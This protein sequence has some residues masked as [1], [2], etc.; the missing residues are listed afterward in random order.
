MSKKL[1][2][3]LDFMIIVVM[4]ISACANPMPT[5]TQTYTPL[6]T[7]VPT[8]TQTSTPLP[9][10]APTV[11]LTP[12]RPGIPAPIVPDV[13][14]KITVDNVSKLA[15]LTS[16]GEG[17][18]LN[19]QLSPDKKWIVFGTANGV[20]VLDANTLKKALFLPT[21]IKPYGI[22]FIDGGNKLTARDCFQGYVWAFPEGEEIS[23]LQ[24]KWVDHPYWWGCTSFPDSK[25]EYAFGYVKLPPSE[26]MVGLYRLS[27]GDVQ[28]TLNYKIKDFIRSTEEKLI[29][30]NAEKNLIAIIDAEENLVIIQYQ[31]GKILKEIP[32]NGIKELFFSPDG[33]TLIG[34]FDNQIKFWS[35]DDFQLI[36]T[37]TAYGLQSFKFSPDNSI[38]AIFT[39]DKTIRLLRVSDRKLIDATTGI[40]LAFTSDSQGVIVDK[41]KGSVGYYNINPDRSKV[42]LANSFQGKGA[43]NFYG[44]YN[45]FALAG[46]SDDRTTLLIL[47]NVDST[48]W[49][50]KEIVIY[51]LLTGSLLQKYSLFPEFRAAIVTDVAW[52][53]SLET[54][55]VLIEDVG[56]TTSF[57]VLDLKSGSF[58]KISDSDFVLKALNFSSKSDLVVSLRGNEVYSWD[59]K[60]NSYWQLSGYQN[61]LPDWPVMPKISFSP[62]DKMILVSDVFNVTHFY[63]P[64]DYSTFQA[65]KEGKFLYLKNGYY[66]WTD[67]SEIVFYNKQGTEINR[68]GSGNTAIDFNSTQGL[69][70]ALSE[71]GL[72]VW[73]VSTVSSEMLLFSEKVSDDY[74]PG[75]C[76]VG[77]SPNGNYV[78]TAGQNVTIWDTTAGK[79][80]YELEGGWRANFAFSP[81]S[82]MIALSKN[83]PFGNLI[84][85][86]DLSTGKSIFSTEPYLYDG[87]FPPE[88][89]F[90]PDGK[91]L[92]VLP[93][94]GYVSIWGIP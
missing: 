61:Y 87:R 83:T 42:E 16:L 24:F 19:M 30:L 21:A 51:D 47:N 94:Y 66:I 37:V 60:N 27:D 59:I 23:R 25:W 71:E 13:S 17:D 70:A 33:K 88:I 49:N 54:F 52:L 31:S 76:Q 45:G 68:I 69:L 92:A 86:F 84:S 7:V 26:Y 56:A 46:V 12:T 89:S 6:P 85:I 55:G 75:C 34:I 48:S 18:L 77:I 36:D 29:A 91:Y 38:L 28:Y 2:F 64:T 73:D 5:V 3:V 10:V 20:L 63:S 11:I 90:S 43:D 80:M 62:D 15:R 67:G 74:F 50:K 81:D 82:K 35:V 78:A 93:S 22:S 44:N 72:K 79:L 32:A 40:G 4:F 1:L 58:T 14:E 9:T 39:S 65:S 8:I 53:T 41:G 57:V